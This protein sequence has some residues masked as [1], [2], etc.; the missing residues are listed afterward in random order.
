LAGNGCENCHGPGAAHIAAEKGDNEA[1]R[2]ALR[3]LLH[4]T[5]EQ[6][7]TE[8]C[9]KCHDHDNSPE[10]GKNSEKYW[11]EIEH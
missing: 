4:L 10:F 11:S 9:I 1:Q 2:A 8:T 7:K 3:E 5:W 6:A